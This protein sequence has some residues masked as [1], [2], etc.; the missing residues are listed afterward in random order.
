[1]DWS[2]EGGV[3]GVVGKIFIKTVELLKHEI[4]PSFFPSHRGKMLLTTPDKK[5]GIRKACVLV[6]F[7]IRSRLACP[8]PW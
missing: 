1:M 8:S 2:V 6:L 7:Q 5:R 3:W 4:A